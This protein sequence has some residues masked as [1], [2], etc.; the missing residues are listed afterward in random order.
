M[1]NPVTLT[2]EDIG[3][4]EE[5]YWQ[6]Q[7]EPDPAERAKRKNRI[8][9][10]A[11]ALIRKI[12]TSV[13]LEALQRHMCMFDPE[14]KFGTPELFPL[15]LWK[16]LDGKIAHCMAIERKAVRRAAPKEQPMA[17]APQLTPAQ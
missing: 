17:S 9:C 15:G 6:Y 11:K 12:K 7:R 1:P 5:L 8:G 4:L 2:A 14:R 13:E 10:F 16:H 3:R